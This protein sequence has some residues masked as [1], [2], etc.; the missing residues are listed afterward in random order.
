MRRPRRRHRAAAREPISTTPAA[1][2]AVVPTT[3]P[4]AAAVA[5]ALVPAVVAA[6]AT[7]VKAGATCHAVRLA[8]ACWSAA[9]RAIRVA[10]ATLAALAATGGA[11]ATA[12]CGTKECAWPSIAVVAAAH[13][14][15]T[16][17]ATARLAVAG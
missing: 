4:T 13:P 10:R 15:V 8:V 6:A 2:T 3:A 5:A 11:L 7:T 9:V 17:S 1:L 12:T 14:A 16:T